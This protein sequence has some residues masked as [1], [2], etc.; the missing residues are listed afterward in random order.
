VVLADKAYSSRTIRSHLR[1]PGRAGRHPSARGPGRPSQA[2]RSRES[3]AYGDRASDRLLD[4]TYPRDL[5]DLMASHW[6]VFGKLL[7]RDKAYWEARFVL[8]AKVRNPMVEK[9]DAALLAFLDEPRTV[10]E[11]AE[12][13]LVYRPH[14][15]GPHVEPVE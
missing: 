8:L 6:D 13:R 1:R 15:E 14:V 3:R 10:E 7:G 5:Y 12:H 2:P 4:F 9:R 11:I